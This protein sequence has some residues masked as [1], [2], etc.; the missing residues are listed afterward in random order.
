MENFGWIVCVTKRIFLTSQCCRGQGCLYGPGR[1]KHPSHLWHFVGV[2]AGTWV[3][4]FWFGLLT[5]TFMRA[6]FTLN[7]MLE[8]C[9]FCHQVCLHFYWPEL[10]LRG[11]FL[12][13]VVDMVL[14][15]SSSSDLQHSVGNSAAKRF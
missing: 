2:A 12:L 14:L 7:P 3:I 6:G 5:A 11:Q 15:V 9:A 13:F 8:G 10:L 1:P 4:V